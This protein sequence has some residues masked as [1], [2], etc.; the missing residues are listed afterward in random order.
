MKIRITVGEVALEAELNDTPTARQVTE[1]LPIETTFN[2]WGEEIYFALPVEA[3]LDDTA[4]E[5]VELGDLRY[6]PAGRAFCVFFGQTPMSRP[7]RIVPAGP[8]N[9][10][11]RVL[12]DSTRL[13][14]VM[15]EKEVRVEPM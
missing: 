13:K 2:T 14:E 4:R 8:V 1:V 9:V 7:G 6:W 3:D 11:G 15:G 5:V 10:I 12:G